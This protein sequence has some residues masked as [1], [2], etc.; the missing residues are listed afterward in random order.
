MIQNRHYS[1]ALAESLLDR[2]G[3]PRPPG[4]HA[5]FFYPGSYQPRMN[6]LAW[7]IALAVTLYC[8][9]K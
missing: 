1:N 7:F 2:K 8:S 3:Y 9:F 4:W 5:V 6:S